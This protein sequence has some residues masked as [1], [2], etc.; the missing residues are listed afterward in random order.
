M[1]VEYLDVVK[2]TSNVF[3]TFVVNVYQ[4]LLASKEKYEEIQEV[5]QANFKNSMPCHLNVA[6]QT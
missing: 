2:P 4:V 6:M 3:V 5:T 1:V